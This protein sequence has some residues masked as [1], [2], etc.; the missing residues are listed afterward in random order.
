MNAV[1]TGEQTYKAADWE[2]KFIYK[3]NLRNKNKK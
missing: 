2:E 3:I 1:V